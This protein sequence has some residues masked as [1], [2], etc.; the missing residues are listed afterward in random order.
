MVLQAGTVLVRPGYLRLKL[1]RI[2]VF[3]ACSSHIAGKMLCHT[4]IF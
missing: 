3:V 4:S 1:N 2:K